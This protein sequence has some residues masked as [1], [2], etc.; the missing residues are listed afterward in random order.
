MP[1]GCLITAIPPAYRIHHQDHSDPYTIYI[2]KSDART[3][4]GLPVSHRS[5]DQVLQAESLAED[6]PEHNKMDEIDMDQEIEEGCPAI[7]GYDPGTFVI[8]AFGKA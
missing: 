7:D 2:G 3:L 5:K 1:V 4:C 6:H 8:E